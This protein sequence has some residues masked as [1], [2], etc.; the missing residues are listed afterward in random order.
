M[1]AE[2]DGQPAAPGGIGATSLGVAALR[3]AES[4]RPDRL[5]E[6]PY[7]QR[8]IDAA[9]PLGAMAALL[10]EVT[11]RHT[12]AASGPTGERGRG[13]NVA[14][15]SPPRRFPEPPADDPANPDLLSLMGGQVSL[16]TRFFDDALL[17]AVSAGCRQVVLLA[18]GMD[19]RAYRLRWPSA[20]RLF[21]V[22]LPEVL[23]FKN[24]VLDR[25]GAQPSCARTCVATDLRGDWVA[26]LRAAGFTAQPTAW[27]AEGFLYALDSAAADRFI[28]ALGE[29]SAEGSRLAFDHIR[30][31]DL[32]H[33]ARAAVN[34]ALNDMWQTGPVEP[35]GTWLR[36]HGWEPTTRDIA[37]VA[38]AFGR[39][40]PAAFD[41]SR[42]GT[43]RSWLVVA[44]RRSTAEA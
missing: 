24:G 15:A 22:D 4:R 37:E 44:R 18:S 14:E 7:A 39:P 34:P 30:D 23:D 26:A 32:L 9:A 1:G 33:R 12:E 41:P 25:S 5:F 38:R 11:R 3:A 43:S 10:S 35:P 28:G 2:G 36:R 27:L 17:A 8:L 20:V 29:A 42:A 40:V 19:S 21:E 31:S 16:R 13:P 6:D